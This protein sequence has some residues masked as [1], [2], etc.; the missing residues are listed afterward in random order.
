MAFVLQDE[1]REDALIHMKRKG[2]DAPV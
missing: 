1:I 2:I